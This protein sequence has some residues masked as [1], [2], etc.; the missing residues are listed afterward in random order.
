LSILW[1]AAGFLAVSRTPAAN[2]SVFS[3]RIHSLQSRELPIKSPVI[4]MAMLWHRTLEN[5]PAHR[6]VRDVIAAASRNVQRSTAAY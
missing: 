4:R 2:F 6:W 3:G 1:L 5:H